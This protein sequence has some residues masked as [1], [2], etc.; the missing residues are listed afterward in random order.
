MS[1]SEKL[2]ELRKTKK[3]SQ[4]EV[5]DAIGVSANSYSRWESGAN[6]PRKTAIKKLSDYF[7]EDLSATAEVSQSEVLQLDAARPDDS[8]APAKVVAKDA[9][10]STGRKPKKVEP[11]KPAPKKDTPKKEKAKRD[12]DIHAELQYAGKAI[13]M[14]EIIDRAKEACGNKVDKIDIYIKPEESRVYYVSGNSVG[15]FEI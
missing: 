15:S 5:A 9:K 11:K 12:S 3:V 7:G 2:V 4:K 10:K 1:I 8:E 13:P 6:A 14:T